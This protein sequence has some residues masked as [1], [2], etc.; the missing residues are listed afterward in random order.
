MGWKKKIFASGD[1]PAGFGISWYGG[2]PLDIVI[3]LVGFTPF[4]PLCQGE[5]HPPARKMVFSIISYIIC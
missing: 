5:K 4:S 2:T 3:Y 1:R